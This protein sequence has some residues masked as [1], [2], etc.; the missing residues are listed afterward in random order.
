VTL[1]EANSD[2]INWMRQRSRW[3]KGYL[4]TM[5]VHLRQPLRLRRE[6]GTVAALRLVNMLGA[7]PFT[8]AFNLVFWMVMLAWIA[9]RPHVVGVFFAPIPYYLCL[10]LFLLVT[11]GSVYAGLIVAQA[12][13]KPHLWWAAMLA[14]LYWA[15]QSAAAVKALYQLLFR[16]F[17]WEK[18]VHGL[19]SVTEP[20]KE[21]HSS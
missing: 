8:N 16:P 9:G 10:V 12:L 4:Q 21:N 6:I 18:T 15:L 11:S 17:F 3:Y 14:P 5:I 19:A 13:G 2:V 7:V 1:E 20:L